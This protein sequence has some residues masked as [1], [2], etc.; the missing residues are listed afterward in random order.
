MTGP[1]GVPSYL[2]V[3]VADLEVSVEWYGAALGCVLDEKGT[4]WACLV[5]PN[6]TMVELFAGDPA[7]PGLTHPSCGL[8]SER[9]VLAGYA[10]EDPLVA[11]EAMRIVR[12]FP[13]WIV[14]ATDDG[15][16]LV[17]QHRDVGPGRG[18]VGFHSAGHA[19][20]ERVIPVVLADRT[21]T[22]TDPDGTTIELIA[23]R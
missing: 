18:L 4:D 8:D 23:R 6:N 15:Q 2:A 10:V 20:R 1:V 21:E 17:L 13:G 5:W 7:W 16:Q 12:Q 22:L 9:P 3:A 11:A 19:G 14:A